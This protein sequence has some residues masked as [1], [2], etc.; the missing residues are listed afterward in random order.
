MSTEKHW[1]IPPE[2][3]RICREKAVASLNARA[4]SYPGLIDDL[5]HLLGLCEGV[6]IHDLTI[7]DDNLW[8]GLRIREP[9]SIVRFQYYCAGAN[10]PSSVYEEGLPTDAESTADALGRLVW[11]FRFENSELPENLK[12][13]CFFMA[14]DLR[15]RGVLS[16]PEYGSLLSRLGGARRK[17]PR[18]KRE[19]RSKS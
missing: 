14:R 15:E 5:F 1:N 12:I 16:D 18:E 4:G 9:K 19:R 17:L 7:R 6:V 10:I 13:F 3:L 8:L 11:T 2:E